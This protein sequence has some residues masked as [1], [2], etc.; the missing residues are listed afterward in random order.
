MRRETNDSPWAEGEEERMWVEGI[1]WFVRCSIIEKSITWR[2]DMPFP[3]PFRYWILSPLLYIS[4]CVSTTRPSHHDDHDVD[5]VICSQ[6]FLSCVT[7]T[8]F[9]IFSFII[10]V[11]DFIIIPVFILTPIVIRSRLIHINPSSLSSVQAHEN[12]SRW[13]SC[14]QMIIRNNS[15]WQTALFSCCCYILLF[16]WSLTSISIISTPHPLWHSIEWSHQTIIWW[17]FIHLTLVKCATTSLQHLV[18]EMQSLI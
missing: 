18:N 4:G 8:F 14:H 12:Y 17:V 7:F 1:K 11:T 3:H 15:S 13:S 6:L 5:C 2:H 10:I 16:C 9:I